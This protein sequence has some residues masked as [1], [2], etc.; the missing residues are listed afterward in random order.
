[1]NEQGGKENISVGYHAIEFLLWGQDDPN[2]SLQ[3]PGNRPYTDYVSGG[4][5]ASNESRRKDYLLAVTNSLVANLQLMVNEWDPN[6]S[7]NY[8][9]TFL[10]LPNNTALQYMLTAI[11]TLSK[12]ELAGERMFVALSNQDQEDEHSCF[13]D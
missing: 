5:T 12:S 8:M 9:E 10:A 3:T 4:G 11:G 1:L 2:T 7:G 6:T 13:S